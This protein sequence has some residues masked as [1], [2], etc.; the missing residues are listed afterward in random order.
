MVFKIKH[1]N[2][3]VVLLITELQGIT[4][5]EIQALLLRYIFAEYNKHDATFLN[6]FL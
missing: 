3:N 2:K 4:S 6:L 1:A 5:I